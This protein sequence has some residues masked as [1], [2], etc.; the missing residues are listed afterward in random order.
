MKSLRNRF[1]FD[2]R[3]IYAAECRIADALPRMAKAD[4][5]DALKR[6]IRAHATE[7]AS[8]LVQ[9]EK[10]FGC[11]GQLPKAELPKARVSKNPPSGVEYQV[12]LANDAELISAL[13]MLDRQKTGS[14]GSHREWEIASYRCLH[15]WANHF[16]NSEGADLLEQILQ[17]EENS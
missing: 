10:L 15:Q 3:E 16:G 14:Y 7:T 17:D 1:L 5:S 11:F 9:V 4:A 6:A 12:S 8:H 13:E 2:L